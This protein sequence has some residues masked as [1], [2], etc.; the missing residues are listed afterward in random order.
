MAA[1]IEG[2]LEIGRRIRDL[3]EKKGITQKAFADLLGVTQGRVS[4]IERGASIPEGM[5]PVLCSIFK[6]DEDYI[7]TGKSDNG[8]EGREYQDSEK[9]YRNAVDAALWNHNY[10]KVKHPVSCAPNIKLDNAD[11]DYK[12][13]AKILRRTDCTMTVRVRAVYD[14]DCINGTGKILTPETIYTFAVRC[15]YL[16]RGYTWEAFEVDRKFVN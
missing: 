15:L 16:G 12:D 11:P 9:N 13:I 8:V 2:S 7:L 3:R 1:C 10:K 6:V 14:D 5:L 4:Q